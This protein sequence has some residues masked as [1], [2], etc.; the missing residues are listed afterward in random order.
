VSIRRRT[1]DKKKFEKM[2]EMMKGCCKDEESMNCWAMMRKMMRCG[3]GME[4]EEKKKDA[5]ET[6]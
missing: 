4:A 1:M 6:E 2:V 3:Q 5:G